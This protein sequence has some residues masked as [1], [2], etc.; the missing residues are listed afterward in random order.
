VGGR[1]L[2]LEPLPPSGELRLLTA[3]A[4]PVGCADLSSLYT[5]VECGGVVDQHSQQGRLER[6]AVTAYQIV[7]VIRDHSFSHPNHVGSIMHVNTA[8]ARKYGPGL[9]KFGTKQT[10]K[11]AKNAKIAKRG[12]KRKI[13]KYRRKTQRV[14][15][16]AKSGENAK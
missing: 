3:Q 12:E 8:R 11:M 4:A 7:T 9:Q 16:N 14:E 2:N 1:R 5:Q 15:K 10:A 6:R 13:S